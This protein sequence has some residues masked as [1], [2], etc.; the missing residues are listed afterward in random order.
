MSTR[1]RRNKQPPT[2]R[3]TRDDGDGP[4]VEI[5]QT[6]RS[7]AAVASTARSARARSRL[8]A[9]TVDL[10]ATPDEDSTGLEG[11]GAVI[12]RIGPDEFLRGL[13]STLGRMQAHLDELKRD[14]DD[15]FKFP[16]PRSDADGSNTTPPPPRAA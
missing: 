14:A 6:F 2:L 5:A 16:M 3:L 4:R 13:E 10:P 8:V 1:S 9:G 7:Q 11:V 12:G 15:V